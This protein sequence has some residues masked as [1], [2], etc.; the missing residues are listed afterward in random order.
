MNQML[1]DTATADARRLLATRAARGFAD[2]IASVLLPSFLTRLGFSPLEVG[3]IVAATLLG[4]AALTLV[5][6]L[7]GR[8]F[9]R[10]A[11]LLGASALM[12]ATGVGFFSATQ[13]WPLLV[14]AFVGTLNP[15]AGDVT[16]FLP[17]EQAV[18]AEAAAPRHRT[19][20]FAWY[21]LAGAFAGAVG[22][23]ASGAADALAQSANLEAAFAERLGFL[24]YAALGAA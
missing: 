18:L 20:L 7:F 2:G 11:L 1:P 8:R 12:F 17:T 4:S 24:I 13:F 16:L 5:V 19:G 15:S 10:R 23:L 21:N 22:S 9:P 6:G 3:A 14:I